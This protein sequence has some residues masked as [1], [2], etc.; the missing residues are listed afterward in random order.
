MLPMIEMDGLMVCKQ[1]LAFSILEFQ[2][3]G[4]SAKY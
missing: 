3:I 4:K 2:N 1:M